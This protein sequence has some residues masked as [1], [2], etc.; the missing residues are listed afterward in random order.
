M[1]N[2]MKYFVYIG[3][4]PAW[5]K[6]YLLLLILGLLLV[7]F[8]Y[9]PVPVHGYKIRKITGGIILIAAIAGFSTQIIRSKLPVAEKRQRL[10]YQLAQTNDKSLALYNEYVNEDEQLSRVDYLFVAQK[11]QRILHPHF[12]KPKDNDSSD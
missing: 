6:I 5:I 12:R 1:E 9:L 4:G 8:R 7:C 3:L 10:L 11:I 2:L